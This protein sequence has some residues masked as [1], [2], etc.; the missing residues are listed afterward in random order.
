MFVPF[1]FLLGPERYGGGVLCLVLL[2]G[3]AGKVRRPYR[4]LVNGVIVTP[5]PR[6]FRGVRE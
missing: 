2:D 5:S 3:V 6:E 4:C 1:P